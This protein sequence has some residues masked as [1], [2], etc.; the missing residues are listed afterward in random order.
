[1]W[2]HPG[3]RGPEASAGRLR[4]SAAPPLEA[5][6]RVTDPERFRLL[7]EA[8]LEIVRRLEH[9]FDVERAEGYGLDGELER[10]LDLAGPCIG[11]RPSDPGAAPIVAAFTSFPGLHVRFGRWHREAFPAC[12]CDACDES[13][14]RGIGRLEAMVESVIHGRFREA[15]RRPL[16]PFMGY[17]WVEAEFQSPAGSR[18]T[19]SRLAPPQRAPN[20]R[21]SPPGGPEL[22]TVAP[23]RGPR[24]GIGPR[25]SA[26]PSTARGRCFPVERGCS[27][28]LT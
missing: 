21:W 22:G 2:T 14:E 23:A 9:D 8:M 13:A 28:H 7:H 24:L 3:G 15:L 12:G 20:V 26:P 4:E 17:G 6:G 19:G 10:G 16:L 1:M 5:Y 25:C 27:C 18:S 11:L